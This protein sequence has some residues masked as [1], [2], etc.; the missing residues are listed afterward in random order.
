MLLTSKRFQDTPLNS[1][2]PDG[3]TH[4]LMEEHPD[5]GSGAILAP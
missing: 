3:S 1:L 4:I 2:E 5:R